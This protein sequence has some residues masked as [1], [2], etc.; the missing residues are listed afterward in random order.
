M[1]AL[2]PFNIIIAQNHLEYVFPENVQNEL[3][4]Y[5]LAQLDNELSQEFYVI[6]HQDYDQNLGNTYRV[7]V[8]T[9]SESLSEDVKYL[10]DNSNRII[11][12]HS[13]IIPVILEEDFKFLAFGYGKRGDKEYPIRLRIISE[14]FAIHF[15]PTGEIIKVGW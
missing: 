11:K 7:Y 10:L 3:N 13:K 2:L 1:L 12:M 14:S 15:K 8:R 6:V 5:I 9:R 4:K